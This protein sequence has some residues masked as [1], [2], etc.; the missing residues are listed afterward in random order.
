MMIL[1]IIEIILMNKLIFSEILAEKYTLLNRLG[2][3]TF[4][5][6]HTAVNNETG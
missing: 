5:I 4:A 3:G 1:V 6:V 2:E